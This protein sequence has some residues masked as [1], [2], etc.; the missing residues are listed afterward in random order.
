MNSSLLDRFLDPQGG[1]RRHRV[2][3]TLVFCILQVTEEVL[4]DRVGTPDQ[5]IGVTGALTVLIAVVAGILLGIR[6]GVVVAIVGTAAFYVS[7][8]GYGTTTPLTSTLAAGI[9]WTAA[10]V[11]AGLVADALRNEILAR[12]AA[13]DA[14]VAL[15]ERLGRNLMPSISDRVGDYRIASSYRPGEARIEL[16]GDFYDVLELDDGSLAVVI[17]DVSGHGPDAAS[18]GAVLRTAWQALVRAHVEP[19]RLVAVMTA[20]LEREMAASDSFATL[21]MAAIDSDARGVRLILLGHPPPLLIAGSV[22]PLTMEPLPPVGVAGPGR[23]VASE[24]P[25]PPGWGLLF[26][27]DGLVEGR[28]SPGGQERYG[29]ERLADRLARECITG[30]GAPDANACLESVVGDVEVAHGGRLPD[31]VAVLLISSEVA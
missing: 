19:E 9:V 16:G 14:V 31:D 18:L 1:M 30:P 25:L 21:C 7:V 2:L 6:S 28:A 26:Y 15:H 27:T 12:R 13:R 24:H 5:I 4:L 22:A 23:V 3:W 11:L 20:V 10:A 29:V 8:S 17:G